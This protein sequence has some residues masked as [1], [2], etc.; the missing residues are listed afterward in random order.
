MAV[1][2]VADAVISASFSKSCSCNH[3]FLL[4][5]GTEKRLEM[6]QK[7]IAMGSADAIRG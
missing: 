2:L 6:E 3:L 5:K 7:K 1:D 4:L